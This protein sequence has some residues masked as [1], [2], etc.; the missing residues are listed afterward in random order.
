MPLSWA[1][2]WDRFEDD[3]PRANLGIGTDEVVQRLELPGSRIIGMAHEDPMKMKDQRHRKGLGILCNEVVDCIPVT[4]KFALGPVPVRAGRAATHE[5]Q[6]A[7]VVED[8][9]LD[10]ARRCDRV[11]ARTSSQ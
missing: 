7:L 11:E 3:C 2:S 8:D 4:R 10:R 9:V 5:L 1:A 6:G